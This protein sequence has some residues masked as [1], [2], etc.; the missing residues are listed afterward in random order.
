MA[1][2]SC[3]ATN[4]TPPAQGAITGNLNINGGSVSVAG[5]VFGGTG[6]SN[7]TLNSGTLDI[8]GHN[9]G[10]A[11]GSSNPVNGNPTGPITTLNFQAGTLKNV[12]E[13]NGGANG[14]TKTG[15]GTLTIS[16]N[17][18]YSGPT[19]VTQGTLT[20]GNNNAIKAGAATPV[21][22][23]VLNGGTFATGGFSDTLGTLTLAANSILD[24]APEPAFCTS[25]AATT[26]STASLGADR[27]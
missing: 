16:G 6:V 17:N 24:L 13:I 8:Q 22:S 20:L 18:T 11:A 25:P 27:R 21:S 26:P 7:L 1:S 14:L 15:T 3:W 23:L 19:T 9:L 12:A 10:V 4:P 5:D 2:P